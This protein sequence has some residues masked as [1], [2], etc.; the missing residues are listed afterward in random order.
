MLSD[1]DQLIC[2]GKVSTLECE[3]A[4]KGMKNNKSPGYDGLTV[5]FYKTFW[6]DLS[7]LMINSFNESFHDGKLSEMQN[8]SVLSLIHKKNER[9]YLKNYRPISLTNV[10]YRILAFALSMHLQKVITKI[11]STEQTGYIKKQFIGINIRAILDVCK[12]IEA[13]NSARILLLDFEKAF[14]S[15]EWTFLFSTLKK[16]NFGKEFIQWIKIL[17]I[18][19]KAIIKNNGYLSNKINIKRGIR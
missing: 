8:T 3:Q 17:Y 16:F 9:T 1:K 13:N 4:L 2:E 14:V 10:D 19:P 5:E 6:Q 12:N 7:D 15:V 11:I 18:G